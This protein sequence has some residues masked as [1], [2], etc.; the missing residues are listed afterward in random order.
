MKR[1]ILTDARSLFANKTSDPNRMRPYIGDDGGAYILVHK[2]GDRNDPKNYRTE[3]VV[4]ATLRPDEWKAIDSTVAMVSRARLTGFEDLR[5]NGLV[6][7][8][9]NAMGTTVL[10]WGTMTDAMEAT[11]S[12]DPVKRGGNDRPLFGEKFLPIPVV[13]ADFQIGERYLQTSRNLGNGL[14]T[15]QVEMAAQRVVEKLEATLWGTTATLTYGGGTIHSYLSHPD[16]NTMSLGTSWATETPPNIIADV[17]AMKQALINDRKYGPYMIYVPIGYETTMDQD[18]KDVGASVTLTI[19]S[20]IMQIDKIQG[21]KVVDT[22]PANTVLMV[23]MTRDVVDFVDG[24]PLRTVQWDS[25]GGF[26]H[27]YKILTIQVPRVKSD[28]DGKS[29]IV[30]LS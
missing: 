9:P 7:N 19:R 24:I 21:I 26:V 25:E 23:S 11:I 1:K 30:K 12:M 15:I 10:T 6:Y 16:I 4:N 8:L 20:R 28:P 29:G 13:H 2:G 17:I 5:R 3:L 22:L 14:D 27:N 18:Y